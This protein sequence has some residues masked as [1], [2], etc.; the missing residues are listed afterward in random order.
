MIK[1]NW[2]GEALEFTK[3]HNCHQEVV[4]QLIEEAM[5]RGAELVVSKVTE[6]IIDAADKAVSKRKNNVRP[7]SGA[8]KTIKL[9]HED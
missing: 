5:K 8:S 2:R 1:I 6:K 3:K 7:D 9:P 4:V